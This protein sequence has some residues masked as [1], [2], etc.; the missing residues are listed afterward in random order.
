MLSAFVLHPPIWA[1]E[2]RADSQATQTGDNEYE[3]QQHKR[4]NDVFADIGQL[5]PRDIKPGCNQ[6]VRHHGLTQP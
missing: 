4:A 1:R 5:I 3:E 6:L 2:H